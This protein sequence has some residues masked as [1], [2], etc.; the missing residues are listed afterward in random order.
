ME[1]GKKKG[2]GIALGMIIG[3]G[4]GI[5]MDNIGA[6]MAIGLAFGAGLEAK[7]NADRSTNK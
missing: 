2:S 6:W 4:I 3:A 1:K 5:V 7:W